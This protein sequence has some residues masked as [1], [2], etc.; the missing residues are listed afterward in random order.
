MIATA[1]LDEMTQKLHAAPSGKATKA[2]VRGYADSTGATISSLYRWA[3]SRGWTS[4]KA[5]RT[6]AGI[7]RTGISDEALDKIAAM[8]LM[9]RRKTGMIIM[10]TNRAREIMDDAGTLGAE[11]SDSTLNRYLRERRIDSKHL[12]DNVRGHGPHSGTRA[13][14]INHCHL[15][16]VSV[17]LQWRFNTKR[18]VAVDEDLETSKNK[19]EQLRKR[20]ELLHRYVLVDMASGCFFV[21][22]F[23][24]LGENTEN[25]IRFLYNAWTPKPQLP[26]SGFP[27]MVYTDKGSSIQSAAIKNLLDNLHIDQDAHEAGNARATGGVEV[28][29]RIWQED[30]E[31]GL[32]LAPAK[33]L[34]SLNRLAFDRVVYYNATKVMRRHGQTRTDCYLKHAKKMTLRLP[35]P[36]HIFYQLAHSAP[37]TRV[38]QGD[39]TISY[40]GKNYE[41]KKSVYYNRSDLVGEK[42]L[43]QFSPIHYPRVEIK[44]DGIYWEAEPLE[45]D[46]FGVS[47]EKAII[48]EEYKSQQY[49]TTQQFIHQ[50]AKE[51]KE[52]NALEKEAGAVFGHHAAKLGNVR[53]IAPRGEVETP[54]EAFRVE[55]FDVTGTR[56]M[57][58]SPMRSRTW[59]I[60][61]LMDEQILLPGLKGPGDRALV[62]GLMDRKAEIEEDVVLE[63]VRRAEEPVAVRRSA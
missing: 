39:L 3:R 13:K 16:D 28:Y 41:I 54:E 59:V 25:L 36:E 11:V 45:Y 14:G 62:D 5:V 21:Q 10:K 51:M 15:F 49:S 20:G 52:E 1:I 24:A 22:Y 56:R 30:F 55:G 34:E 61:K 44:H 33:G 47:M 60:Q 40:K 27:E 9:S 57:G 58:P 4:G 46:E 43:V 63:F 37:E 42:V 6:D 29:M 38:V 50:K 35:P 12:K 53:Y 7:R 48:G 19:V 18:I 31:S 26:L 23:Y 17:C 8:K 2:I 32:R